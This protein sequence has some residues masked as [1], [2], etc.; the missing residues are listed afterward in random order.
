MP[1]GHNLQHMPLGSGDGVLST[2]ESCYLILGLSQNFN[3]IQKEK[4]RHGGGLGALRP[5]WTLKNGTSTF[6]FHSNEI[7]LKF[8]RPPSIRTLH[9]TGA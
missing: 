9:A 7:L 8:I 1:S 5:L 6:N 3:R 2:L 4:R